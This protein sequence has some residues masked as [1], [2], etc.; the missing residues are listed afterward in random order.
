LA[1]QFATLDSMTIDSAGRILSADARVGFEDVQMFLSC[2]TGPDGLASV[3]FSAADFDGNQTVDLRDARRF[4][5]DF[6]P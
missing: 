6:R 5:L 2:A 1:G 4:L 3:D